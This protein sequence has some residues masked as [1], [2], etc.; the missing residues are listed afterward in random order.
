[1][2]ARS[3]KQ[4]VRRIITAAIFA[5]MLILFLLFLNYLTTDRQSLENSGTTRPVFAHTV[6]EPLTL[7]VTA[8][9]AIHLSDK[10][11]I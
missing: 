4:L 1:M 7:C 6:E 5:V 8:S 3:R 11:A 9:A 10:R 2:S